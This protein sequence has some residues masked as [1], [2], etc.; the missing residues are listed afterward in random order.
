MNIQ[1]QLRTALENI[2]RLKKELYKTQGLHK[3][4][5]RVLMIKMK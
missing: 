5:S 1:E 4:D 2:D 3:L